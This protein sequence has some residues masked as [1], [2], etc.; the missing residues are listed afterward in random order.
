MAQ[1]NVELEHELLQTLDK[2]YKDSANFT[3]DPGPVY[4][5]VSYHDG[6]VWNCLVDTSEEGDLKRGVHLR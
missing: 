3:L 5:I 1:D 4:D 6:N 2:K